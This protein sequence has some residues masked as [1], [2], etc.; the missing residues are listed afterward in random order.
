MKKALYVE[1]DT[2]K[3][4]GEIQ[5]LTQRDYFTHRH[6]KSPLH[7]MFISTWSCRHE[8]TCDHSDPTEAEMVTSQ[9][10]S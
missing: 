6:L 10:Q 4:G 9:H 1:E 8:L 3:K 5:H 2:F 7:T